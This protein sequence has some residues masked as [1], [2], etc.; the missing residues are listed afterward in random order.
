MTDDNE[1]RYRRAREV[2]ADAGWLF[3]DFVNNEMRRVL[4]SDPEVQA[5][6]AERIE[7]EGGGGCSTNGPG[8]APR[9]IWLIGGLLGACACLR[10]QL[11]P[12]RRSR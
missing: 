9:G 2:L 4:T 3:D 7:L 8:S 11:A 10:R 6:I 12:R 1:Q 5:A